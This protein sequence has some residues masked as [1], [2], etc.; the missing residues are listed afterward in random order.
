MLIA[1]LKIFCIGAGIVL[2]TEFTYKGLK[3]KDKYLFY[4]GLVLLL[5]TALF[6]LV[7]F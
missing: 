2:S 5:L 6:T 4:E 7:V 3:G 1:L